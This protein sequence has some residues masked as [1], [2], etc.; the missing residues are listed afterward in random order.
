MWRAEGNIV[1]L[2][3]SQHGFLTQVETT[4]CNTVLDADEPGSGSVIQLQHLLSELMSAEHEELEGMD[5]DEGSEQL[6]RAHYFVMNCCS[7]C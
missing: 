3:M 6:V 1:L 7:L 2:A 5:E 4:V